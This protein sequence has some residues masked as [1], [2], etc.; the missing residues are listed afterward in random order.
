LARRS[1]SCCRCYSMRLLEGRGACARGQIDARSRRIAIEAEFA[2]E[3][4][5][6]SARSR[7]VRARGLPQSRRGTSL[8]CTQA[9]APS[10]CMKLLRHHTRLP[11]S[12]HCDHQAVGSYTQE[13]ILWSWCC[14]DQRCSEGCVGHLE[15]CTRWQPPGSSRRRCTLERHRSGCGSAPRRS[16]KRE[17][18]GRRGARASILSAG[19]WGGYTCVW[20]GDILARGAQVRGSSE[21]TGAKQRRE[22]ARTTSLV[23][24]VDSGSPKRVALAVDE[25][26]VAIVQRPTGRVAPSIWILCAIAVRRSESLPVLADNPPRRTRLFPLSPPKK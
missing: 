3:R 13:G 4:Y 26:C 11:R 5:Q 2:C 9:A 24:K 15:R 22:A 17:R 7:L 14:C 19:T 20:S 21:V 10:S 23:S 6:R 8:R 25:V 18:R 12:D 16:S 1:A